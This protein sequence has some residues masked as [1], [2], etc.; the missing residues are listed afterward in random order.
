[1]HPR[2][3]FTLIEMVIVITVSAVLMGIGTGILCML[4]Q[5]ERL[6]RRDLHAGTSVARLAE[7]F[8]QDVHA[9][10]RAPRNLDRASCRL[11]LPPDRKV[12]YLFK[13]G[14]ASRTEWGS[15]EVLLRQESYELPAEVV[16]R[17][18]VSADSRPAVACLLLEQPH[19]GPWRVEAVVGRDGRFTK[20]PQR[21]EK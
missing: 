1:M 13:P 7:Q 18:E 11:Q 9:A 14:I 16:A 10:A 15:N 4:L 3:G 20:K 17:V 2:R 19:G 12:V 8:R 21:S 6:A 5:S